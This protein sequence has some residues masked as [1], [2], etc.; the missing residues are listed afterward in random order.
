MTTMPAEPIVLRA[1][2]LA[3]AGFAHAFSTRLGG[4]SEG[5]YASLNLGR[6]VGD[7]L[8]RVHENT[9][10][11]ATASGLDRSRIFEASQVHGNA[12]IEVHASDEPPTVRA[13]QA[14][15]LVARVPGDAVGV[16]TADCVPVLLADRRTGVVAAAHAGWRG[17]V[18]RVVLEALRAMQSD[19][20]DIV[21]A[22]GP[23]IGPC[24]FEV[25]DD[26]AQQLGHAGGDGVVIRRGPSKPHVDL[27]RAVEHQ[28]HDVGV[29]TIDTLGRCTVCEGEHFFS[30]RRDGQKSGRMLAA[31]AARAA[32]VPS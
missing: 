16:R 1:E 30:Y 17:V 32:K 27:W 5:P 26:V 15:A 4:V 24:C 28:L 23:S 9:R 13:R 2:R 20:A 19:P 8:E 18:A 10:R 25:G 22:V 21:A 7:D 29:R 3:A 6:A 14:D 11:F 12:V 31:I